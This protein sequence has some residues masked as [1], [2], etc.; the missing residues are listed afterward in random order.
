MRPA[1]ASPYNVGMNRLLSLSALILAASAAQAAVQGPARGP[2]DP[3]I[4]V[5][6]RQPRFS[7]ALGLQLKRLPELVLSP[8]LGREQFRELAAEAAPT[9]A[10]QFHLEPM[11]IAL[12][13]LATPE[14]AQLH[15]EPLAELVG[16][17][18]MGQLLVARTLYIL[19]SR[20]QPEMVRQMGLL[21]A[22]FTLNDA[23]RIEG[24]AASLGRF[25]DGAGSDAAPE[26]PAVAADA[27]T[28]AGK[29][30][31]ELAPAAKPADA[32][33]AAETAAAP[34]ANSAP[35]DKIPNSAEELMEMF[36][37]AKATEK[38]LNATILAAL[39]ARHETSEQEMRRRITNIVKMYPLLEA[40]RAAN[41]TLRKLFEDDNAFQ[42]QYAARLSR[43]QHEAWIANE[44]VG[45]KYVEYTQAV[46]Q[47]MR[48]RVKAGGVLIPTA[49]VKDQVKIG[50]DLFENPSKK[51][52][53]EAKH[54]V[55]ADEAEKAAFSARFREA[56][57]R[58][59]EGEPWLINTVAG[60][61][62]TLVGLAV[63]HQ[64]ETWGGGRVK[65][66]NGLQQ[67]NVAGA[68]AAVYTDKVLHGLESARTQAEFLDVI[69]D[70]SRVINVGW[71]LNNP[72]GGFTDKL[73]Y[74]PFHP[75]ANIGIGIS[76]IRK[77]TITLK[78]TLELL[79]DNPEIRLSSRVRA[80]LDAA[81]AN[82]LGEALEQAVEPGGEKLSAA[83]LAQRVGPVKLAADNSNILDYLAWIFSS[84][85]LIEQHMSEE[86]L[87][88]L[89]K[90]FDAKGRADVV[91][92]VE[93]ALAV[94]EVLEHT[95]DS[96]DAAHTALVPK[97]PAKVRKA[98]ARTGHEFWLAQERATLGKRFVE[99][100]AG[101]QALL[102]ETAAKTKIHSR[103][104]RVGSGDFLSPRARF[105]V[106]A[107]SFARGTAAERAEFA[108]FER[109]FTELTGENFSDADGEPLVE[110]NTTAAPWSALTGMVP[111]KL[112]GSNAMRWVN[113]RNQ[114]LYRFQANGFTPVLTAL[115]DEELVAGLG[116]D[117]VKTRQDALLRVLRRIDTNTRLDNAD[118]GFS[119]LKLAYDVSSE[120]GIGIEAILQDAQLL[121][122]SL[123]TIAKSLGS[124]N[125]PPADAARARS[126][127]TSRLLITAAGLRD[128]DT[129]VKVLERNRVKENF[130]L[131][132][133]EPPAPAK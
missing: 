16:E 6:Q 97:V 86:A 118:R 5:A 21:Q 23:T 58:S 130:T 67:D 18:A 53:F 49:P 81:Y 116:S 2:L 30:T 124:M 3:I 107:A 13:L 102:A 64:P 46:H 65:F 79:R 100:S 71:R 39:A 55:F 128:R 96:N 99:Y 114:T 87:L 50:L 112:K 9:Q 61:W 33:P 70:M 120:G 78:A 17:E 93:N 27:G 80:A 45:P 121:S 111:P 38:N 29:I 20:T 115:F 31:R 32:A 94:L 47:L 44:K 117:Q 132:A 4:A 36:G 103:G 74:K 82:G 73:Q 52:K 85:D 14:L 26:T 43:V 90:A 126:V 57:G 131:K 88:V 104:R 95:Q 56:T 34:S 122:S 51:F 42:P 110:I 113:A 83:I 66:L 54:F 8:S 125:L 101:L 28:G 10:Q 75:D 119:R 98:L 76:D 89:A 41:T 91:R 37:N 1:P 22:E 59:F 84:R 15:R 11:R 133:V 77:D 127:L 129:M 106:T 24:I 123:R 7:Y 63:E 35:T 62:E 48:E 60:E 105:R 40:Q 12:G 68:L 19:R 69:V 109:R 92:N 25:F 72:W 108:E